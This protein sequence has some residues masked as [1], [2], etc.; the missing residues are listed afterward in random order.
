MNAY[1]ESFAAVFYKFFVRRRIPCRSRLFRRAHFVIRY[2]L[3]KPLF[4]FS[5]ALGFYAVGGYAALYRFSF[6]QPLSKENNSRIGQLDGGKPL[7]ITNSVMLPYR[8]VHF[9]TVKQSLL[10]KAVKAK[11][12]IINSGSVNQKA[13]MDIIARREVIEEIEN[14]IVRAH[15][16]DG[17]YEQIS[18]SLPNKSLLVNSV[19][20]PA[21]WIRPIGYALSLVTL[22]AL[23]FV[24]TLYNKLIAALYVISIVLS[25]MLNAL[26]TWNKYHN[27]SLSKRGCVLKISYGKLVKSHHF[28]LYD[29]INGMGLKQH[30]LNKITHTCT[31]FLYAP[32]HQGALSDLSIPLLPIAKIENAQKVIKEFLPD[33][34]SECKGFR[35][36]PS[37]RINYFSL[38][39]F[40]FNLIAAP[41]MVFFAFYERLPLAFPVF[42]LLNTLVLLDCRL[43][44]FNTSFYCGRNIVEAAAGGMFWR[45]LIAKK[46]RFK[47]FAL[48]IR[49]LTRRR[50]CSNQSFMSKASKKLSRRDICAWK[51]TRACKPNAKKPRNN[52]ARFSAGGC[53]ILGN[54]YSLSCLESVANSLP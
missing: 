10:Y 23:Y 38:T 19:L 17:T 6:G 49:F 33:F 9:Y 15:C 20:M 53:F 41:L 37:A 5:I 52:K 12:I 32:G 14:K 43:K 24:D 46:A 40:G 36:P 27:F 45:K 8:N 3:D 31:A 7:F 2:K 25:I 51:P 42:V 35:P 39:V 26:A 29:S 11:R 22:V 30:L 1:R 13:E 44:Y 4:I 18:F 34:E 54:A 28:A 47:R 21:R 48:P 16:G 50:I